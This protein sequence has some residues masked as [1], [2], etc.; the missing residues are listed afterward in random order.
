MADASA[1]TCSRARPETCAVIVALAACAPEPTTSPA[2]NAAQPSVLA[3][4]ENTVHRDD[5][6]T[7]VT[8]GKTDSGAGSIADPRAGRPSSPLRPDAA[9]GQ[10]GR[11]PRP[12]SSATDGTIAC[13]GRCRL[14]SGEHMSRELASGGRL[15]TCA[16][17]PTRRHRVLEP[18]QLRR[19]D[20]GPPSTARG[21]RRADLRAAGRRLPCVLGDDDPTELPTGTFTSVSIG[22]CDHRLSRCA[23]RTDGTHRL[24]GPDY[25]GVTALAGWQIP[26][27]LGGLQPRLRVP[28]DGS[29][30]PLGRPGGRRRRRAGSSSPTGTFTAVAAGWG[31]RA[32]SGPRAR[33]TAGAIAGPS[34]S[35]ERTFRSIAAPN[36][37]RDPL[38]HTTDRASL[39]SAHDDAGP[40]A[41]RLEPG[42]PRLPR[43]CG[44]SARRSRRATRAP[45]RSSPTG[46][47]SCW[48][49]IDK[50]VPKDASP[51][52]PL[53]DGERCDPADAPF[54]LD[55][56]AHRAD[57]SPRS[58]R[59]TRALYART[60][61]SPCWG[62]DSWDPIPKPAKG[63]FAQASVGYTAAASR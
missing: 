15:R 48:G 54:V 59:T 53:V 20:A 33:S 17:R 31:T 36:P 32:R 44:S 9:G 28:T 22:G 61:E 14:A 13:W 45:A 56:T 21:G 60:G 16:V 38:G 19:H 6:I 55:A 29:L 2:A 62:D 35:S 40:A 10:Y 12:A 58:T 51:P 24:L 57:G 42:P 39:W 47:W 30:R 5:R 11:P 63:D 25:Y 41:R 43:P 4:S 18:G 49:D 50:H 1:S 23:V 27:R 7:P 34:T 26:G 37:P 46:P 8:C 52:F 3:L